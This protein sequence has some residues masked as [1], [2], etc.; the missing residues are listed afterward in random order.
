MARYM[1]K[2][3]RR[4][5]PKGEKH[6]GP[7]GTKAEAQRKLRE[8]MGEYKVPGRT[9]RIVRASSLPTTKR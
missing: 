9:G 5:A 4:K 7:Y 3:T 8:H 6:Y 1:V 2:I